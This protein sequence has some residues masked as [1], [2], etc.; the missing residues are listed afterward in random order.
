[1]LYNNS[2]IGDWNTISNKPFNGISEEDFIID[3]NNIISVGTSVKN[4]LHTHTNK[5]LLDKFSSDTNGKLLFNGNAIASDS[6][7]FTALS[8]MLVQGDNITITA[9]ESTQT[10]RFDFTG[11]DFTALSSALTSGTQSGISITADTPNSAINFEVTGIPSLDID[12]EG[13][14]TVNGERGSNPT[15]AQG[16]KGTDGTSPTSK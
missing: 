12:S 15:K 3:E 5:E 2:P 1:M 6:I 11:L 10:I 14:W 4:Q 13:Y 7:D 8:D 9:D 16:E